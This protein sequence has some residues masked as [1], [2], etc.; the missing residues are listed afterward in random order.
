MAYNTSEIDFIEFNYG[1][2]NFD[3]IFGSMYTILQFMTGEGWSVMMY[4]MWERY[5]VW[6]VVTYFVILI[7]FGVFF[8]FNLFIAVLSDSYVKVRT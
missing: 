4:I 7:L 6:M 1:I 3:S 5:P 2:T 8:V